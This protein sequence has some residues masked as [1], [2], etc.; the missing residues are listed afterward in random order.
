MPK[1]VLAYHGAPQ[2][3]SPD[4]GKQHMVDWMAWREGLGA[5]VIDPGLPVGPSQ[6][7]TRGGVQPDGGA[8]PLSGFTVVEASDMAAAL[9][10]A[11]ACPHVARGGSIEVAEALNMQ[12]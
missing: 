9:G 11:Q 12:M 7:V 6:T 4:E 10:M 1:F 5:A 8:N 3:S 2:F